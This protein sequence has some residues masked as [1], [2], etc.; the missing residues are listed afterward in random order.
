MPA[1]SAQCICRRRASPTALRSWGWPTCRRTA[2]R[3]ALDRAGFVGEQLTS[4]DTCGQIND[5]AAAQRIA[6]T[7]NAGELIGAELDVVVEC[8][9][10]PAGGAQHA[11]AAIGAGRHVV[12][13]TVETDALICDMVDW[14]RTCGFDVVAAG[15]GTLY[16][17]KYHYSTPDTVFDLFRFTD[18]Q[19]AV[20]DFNRRYVQ[21]VS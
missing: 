11:L 15:K 18:E 13:V 17:P 5:V 6:V 20:G 3:C 1:S 14:A 9:G 12:M 4:A 21:L 16:R 8:T 2:I 10:N 19:L 7:E